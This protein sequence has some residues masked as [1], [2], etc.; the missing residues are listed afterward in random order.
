MGSM[1]HLLNRY[2]W[3]NA[4][5]IACDFRGYGRIWKQ[6]HTLQPKSIPWLPTR[7]RP[8]MDNAVAETG[9]A[10]HSARQVWS[11]LVLQ[12][13]QHL[14][15]WQVGAV[16][17]ARDL[18]WEHWHIEGATSGFHSTLE[19]YFFEAVSLTWPFILATFFWK[20][21]SIYRFIRVL[22][23]PVSGCWSRLLSVRPGNGRRDTQLRLCHLCRPLCFVLCFCIHVFGVVRN[24]NIQIKTT[25][26]A[27]ITLEFCEKNKVKTPPRVSMVRWPFHTSVLFLMRPN[28]VFV[29]MPCKP[30]CNPLWPFGSWAM[31]RV[32]VGEGGFFIQEDGFE[33][34]HFSMN[35]IM[36][37]WNSTIFFGNPVV[38]TKRSFGFLRILDFFP[39]LRHHPWRPG[40]EALKPWNRSVW[41][42]CDE[43]DDLG[44]APP[45]AVKGTT[46]ASWWNFFKFHRS[47]ILHFRYCNVLLEVGTMHHFVTRK[48]IAIKRHTIQKRT[49]LLG[50][51][52]QA[53]M[54]N[55]C[56]IPK[57]LVKKTFVPWEAPVAA[58][59]IQSVHPW[60]RVPKNL[61]SWGRVKDSPSL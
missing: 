24:W 22:R 45:E 39:R 11:T 23:P 5:K 7:H 60:S 38:S 10:T 57:D 13:K 28:L 50:R 9:R 40:S 16:C 46:W 37:M 26:I 29:S 43:Q 51:L 61:L 35:T 34:S 17:N 14:W 18:M 1:L 56:D 25:Y 19:I 32:E 3:K 12:K 52:L 27:I 8:C 30:R 4:V 31:R 2:V 42:W 33:S 36:T 55:L 54:A 59:V 47:G 21:I 20:N 41:W 58:P 44:S 6:H 53:W 48:S 49:Q 15:S